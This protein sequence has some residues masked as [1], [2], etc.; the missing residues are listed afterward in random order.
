MPA[1]KAISQNLMHSNLSITDGIYGVL[2]ENDVKG[3]IA[4]LGK[5]L[6]IAGIQN[7]NEIIPLLEQIITSIK[8]NKGS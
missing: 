4:A 5:K 7:S 8:E 2:S 6:S 3:Q 1:H